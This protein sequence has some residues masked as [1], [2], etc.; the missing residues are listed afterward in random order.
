M[1]NTWNVPAN[2]GL[3]YRGYKSQKAFGT[4]G[5]PDVVGFLGIVA[6]AAINAVWYQ[7]WGVHL[8]HRPEAGA[9][10]VHLRNT[11]ARPM[12]PAPAAFSPRFLEPLTTST[13]Y[14]N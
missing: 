1:A 2:P 8:R 12:P 3:H 10:V 11:T 6:R 14:S 9:R 4:L 13:N 5:G 7:K